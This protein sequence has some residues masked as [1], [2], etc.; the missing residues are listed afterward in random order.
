[1][2]VGFAVKQASQQS[3]VGWGFGARI[4]FAALSSRH[5]KHLQVGSKYGIKKKT[6]CATGHKYS[7]PGVSRM[8]SLAWR[9]MYKMGGETW[10]KVLPSSSSSDVLKQEG[11]Q[12]RSH[13]HREELRSGERGGAVHPFI[14]PELSGTSGLCNS[15]G[16]NCRREPRK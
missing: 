16:R 2:F 15:R 4:F 12:G 14:S 9:G 3:A 7:S 11:P 10:L 8:R 1:M 6:N 5:S 13:T